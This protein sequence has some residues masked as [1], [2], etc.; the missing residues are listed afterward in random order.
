ML[1]FAWCSPHFLSHPWHRRWLISCSPLAYLYLEPRLS[2]IAAPSPPPLSQHSTLPPPHP[3]LSPTMNSTVHHPQHIVDSS[4]RILEQV[5]LSLSF[6][7]SLRLTIASYHRPHLH[8]SERSLLL[9]S[10]PK[11]RTETVNSSWLFSTLKARKIR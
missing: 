10:S 1:G 6:R 2:L 7:V 11:A 3:A 8:L 9:S 4:W 5:C